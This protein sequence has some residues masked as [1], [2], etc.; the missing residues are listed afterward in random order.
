MGKKFLEKMDGSISVKS[1]VGKGTVLTVKFPM[2]IK[3]ESFI[4]SQTNVDKNISLPK[5]VIRDKLQSIL[6]V[7]N[8][9]STNALV[10]I[11]LDKHYLIDTA[12]NGST[13]ISLANNKIYD[14]ILMDINLGKGIN[15]IETTKEIR[16]INGYENIPIIALTAFALEGDREEFISGGCSEYISKP[17]T[18]SNLL[19][20]IKSLIP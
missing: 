13:A 14:A 8:D 1:E 3:T 11:Y 19:S 18:R 2:R 6:V 7:D 5:T 20:L 10:S 12:K 17:F 9:E 4:A 15:G 16:K